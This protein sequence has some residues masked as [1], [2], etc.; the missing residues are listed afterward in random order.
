MSLYGDPNV[1]QR[2]VSWGGSSRRRNIGG[3]LILGLLLAGFALCKYYSS[4]QLNEVTG[5]TQHINITTEQEIAIGLESTPAMIQQYGGLHP[6]PEG[7]KF[8]KEVGQRVVQN[9]SAKETPY[10]YDFHLLND[11]DVINAFALPGGQVFITQ[12]LFNKLES[13]DQLAGVLGHE[14]G[15]VVA[16]HGAERIA[17]MELTQGLTG[18]AVVASGDYNTAQAAQL[19]ANI[20]N[21]SYGRDQE[22]EADNLGVRFMTQTGYQPEALLGV[23]KIL[24][25]ASGGQS[26]PEFLST[27][28]SPANRMEKIKEAIEQYKDLA[29]AR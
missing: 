27:H 20:V 5:K 29:P 3:G 8:V 9:S 28:P 22:L 23:M 26:Q 18:A 25:E 6:D 11:P 14:V 10:E 16:R 13:E 19:I 7:Q 24:E 15:H 21:M 12:A 2:R 17:Q 1:P 4:S